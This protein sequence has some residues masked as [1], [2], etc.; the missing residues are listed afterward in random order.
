V[1]IAIFGVGGVGGYFGWRLAQ[2]G[3]EVIFVARGQHLKALREVGLKME[4]PDGASVVQPVQAIQDPAEIGP[5]DTVILGVKAW[6][7]PEAAESIRPL[8]GPDTF[9][10]PLQNGVEAPMH[11]SQA[12][13]AEHVCGG[14]C[15]IV[16]LKVGPGHVRHAG[17]EP[18]IAFGELDNRVTERARKLEAA[19]RRVDVN[20]EIPSD[21]HTAMWDKFLFIASF[22]GVASITRAPVGAIRSVPE[23]RR[24]LQDV[25]EEIFAVARA[26]NIALKDNAVEVTMGVVDRLPAE[27]TAS[28]Q[29]DIMAGLPSELSSQS[30]A[31]VR[32]GE[33]VGQ[34]APLNSFIYAS[35]LPMELRARGD[36]SF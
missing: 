2:A 1:R 21:I 11:L 26:R 30:G 5:V 8:I 22:S 9:V 13:G 20:V 18:R 29:R 34:P 16:A 4:T 19:F 36:L 32:L 35:L 6:Q 33:E 7:V 27:G 28:M 10:V 24:I 14:L 15:Y 3:E 23:T 25:M 17:M 31:V 12:L